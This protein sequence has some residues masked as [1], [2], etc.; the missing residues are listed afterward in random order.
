MDN[1]TEV[2]NTLKKF[3]EDHL[4]RDIK[5]TLIKMDKFELAAYLRWLERD[6]YLVGKIDINELCSSLIQEAK[7]GDLEH[8]ITPIIREYR[9]NEILLRK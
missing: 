9:L 4:I 1:L 6:Y 3:R 7:K 2:K 5:E 8:I